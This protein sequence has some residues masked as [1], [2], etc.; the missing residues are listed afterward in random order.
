MTR[1]TIAPMPPVQTKNLTMREGSLKWDIIRSAERFSQVAWLRKGGYRA[2]KWELVQ[3]TCDV[4]GTQRNDGMAI[5]EG[6]YAIAQL[7]DGEEPGTQFALC[8]SLFLNRHIQARPEALVWLE[9][10]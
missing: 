1:S 10:N 5:Q 4:F 7:I 8:Y 3:A 6:G 2:P 9:R